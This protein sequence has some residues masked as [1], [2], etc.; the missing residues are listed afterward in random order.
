MEI[1]RRRIG[2]PHEPGFRTRG[3]PQDI[4]VATGAT[5][6]ERVGALLDQ[7]PGLSRQSDTWL[8]RP[9]RPGPRPVCITGL[10]VH[11]S[12]RWSNATPGAVWPDSPQCSSIRLLSPTPSAPCAVRCTT[13]ISR[14]PC[15]RRWQT[16]LARRLRTRPAPNRGQR[17]GTPA[18]CET[19][20]RHSR[21][22]CGG[23]PGHRTGRRWTG[24]ARAPKCT[25]TARYSILRSAWRGL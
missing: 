11:Q 23:H 2:K 8:I 19:P 16:S 20:A 5:H 1:V 7:L 3:R 10:P 25:T 4:P 24:Q 15:G 21:L 18:I 22:V 14:G 13:G 6:T 17:C 9:A 12:M